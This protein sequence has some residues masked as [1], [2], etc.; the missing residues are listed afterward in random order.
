VSGSCWARLGSRSPAEVVVE[1]VK[2]PLIAERA[3]VVPEELFKEVTFGESGRI[4]NEERSFY[5]WWFSP[6][7][8]SCGSYI[9]WKIVW[10]RPP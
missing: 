10:K 9:W 8:G 7:Q 6:L 1:G 2:A 3:I 5:G 4:N